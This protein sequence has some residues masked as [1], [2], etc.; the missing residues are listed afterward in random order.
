MGLRRKNKTNQLKKQRG[1]QS[2]QNKKQNLKRNMK[3]NK[4]QKRTRKTKKRRNKVRGGAAAED[5]AEDA[6][7]IKRAKLTEEAD[8]DMAD[9]SSSSTSNELTDIQ[10]LQVV[11]KVNL[12]EADEEDV[13]AAAAGEKVNLPE[14]EVQLNAAEERSNQVLVERA[15]SGATTAKDFD[16]VLKTVNVNH[17]QLG[18][19][20]ENVL[21]LSVLIQDTKGG[22][23][24]IIRP[25]ELA[26]NYLIQMHREFDIDL[27]V[28]YLATINNTT[29]NYV[30]SNF[31]ISN[32]QFAAMTQ[33]NDVELRR[34]LNIYIETIVQKKLAKDL[35]RAGKAVHGD[36]EKLNTKLEILKAALLEGTIGTH[37]KNDV[38]LFILGLSLLMANEPISM[39][40]G[41]AMIIASNH[42]NTILDLIENPV[43]GPNFVSL[44]KIIKDL[45][46]HSATYSHIYA[47]EKIYAFTH[48]ERVENMKD[49]AYEMINFTGNALHKMFHV[50]KDPKSEYS[51]FSP[52]GEYLK[53]KRER[54]QALSKYSSS[55]PLE[56][57]GSKN[58]IGNKRN[59]KRN[60]RTKKRKH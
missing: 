55:Q 30:I 41:T 6:K 28:D 5:A 34:E 39:T 46:N 13:A 23:F 36:V 57:G 15:S 21:T 19:I 22:E 25:M 43:Q 31:K 3:T 58:A 59:T 48:D 24:K 17:N 60:S 44:P 37:M 18:N 2:K 9:R 11:Q 8:D 54:E 29:K 27:W 35:E 10:D 32:Q 16:A 12:P 52:F 53:I 38:H 45:V 20:L 26:M 14:E 56:L 1:K 7:R 51:N 50:N 33:A 47:R 40:L 42:K 49:M 4:K